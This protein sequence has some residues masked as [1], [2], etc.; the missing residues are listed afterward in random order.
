MCRVSKIRHVNFQGNACVFLIPF[1]WISMASEIAYR[2]YVCLGRWNDLNTHVG[3]LL[4]KYCCFRRS[5][6]NFGRP[7]MVIR[8]T[9]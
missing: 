4:P 1:A 3:G 5:A 7:T 8:S 2:F 6:R 9:G